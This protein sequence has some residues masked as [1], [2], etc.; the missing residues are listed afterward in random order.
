[1]DGLNEMPPDARRVEDRLT[2]IQVEVAAGFAAV[3]ARLDAAKDHE[4]RLRALE[5]NQMSRDDV[6]A[7]LKEAIE[8]SRRPRWQDVGA[9]VASIATSTGLVLVVA[10]ALGADI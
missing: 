1:M 10:K 4:P 2:M 3:N 9:L 5:Q 6:R 7:M 8:A